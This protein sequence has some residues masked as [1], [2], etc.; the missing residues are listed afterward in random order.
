MKKYKSNINYYLIITPSCALIWMLIF[1][2]TDGR[3]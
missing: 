2:L 3:M 1:I